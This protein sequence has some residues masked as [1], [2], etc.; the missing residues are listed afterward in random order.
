ML[1]HAVSNYVMIEEKSKKKQRWANFANV[2]TTVIGGA[3]D[4]ATGGDGTTGIIAGAATGIVIGELI[5]ENLITMGYKFSQEQELEADRVAV[6]LMKHIGISSS[7]YASALNKLRQEDYR[8]GR[9]IVK[10]KKRSTHPTLDERISKVGEIENVKTDKEYSRKIAQILT[11]DAYVERNI[12]KDY[13]RTIAV[14]NRISDCS[15]LTLDDYLIKIPTLL[16]LSNTEENNRMVLNII[17]NTINDF[18]HPEIKSLSKHEAMVL[19]RLKEINQAKTSLNNYIS[20][21]DVTIEK[22]NKDELKKYFVKEKSWAENTLK[23][24]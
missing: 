24:L 7:Y 19:V 10:T 8:F 16:E 9:E 4:V 14:L 15:S 3:A 1:E 23:R 13:E 18:E 6:A 11:V 17:R 20:Y 21:C 2:A 5:Y 22:T 12:H